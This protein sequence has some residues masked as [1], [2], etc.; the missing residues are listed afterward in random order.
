MSFQAGP[1]LSRTFYG[2]TVTEWAVSLAIAVGSMVLMWAAGRLVLQRLQAVAARTSTDVDDLVAELLAKTKFLFVLL[3]GVWA[4]S[5]TLSLSPTVSSWITEILIVGLLLQGAFWSTGVVNY[6]IEKYRSAEVGLDPD[7]A[8]AMG[9]VSFVV[10]VAIWSVFLLLALQNLGIN[11]TTLVASLG[12]G[13]VAVALALQNVLG[14]LFASLSIVL[15]KPFVVGDFI[16]VDD[17]MGTVEHVGL[18]T[19]RVRSLGGEQLVFSNSDLLAS[20]IRNYKRMDERRIVFSFGVTYDTGHDRLK[21]IPGIVRSIVEALEQTR[22][23]RS[24]F[25][26]FGDSA[27]NFE[28]VYYMLVPDY[29]AYMDTQQAI[30]LELYRRLQEAGVDFAFP[31]RTVHV[32]HSEDRQGATQ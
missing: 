21:E 25:K 23:D 28:T 10:R 4:G 11:V 15:D 3:V 31:T 9:A 5:R 29:N 14:D 13:G 27:L 30:N 20:R 8:T 19:T 16:I 1:F 22:F 17:L 6:V 32:E 26:G 7:A 18:K 2:N 24:H 12:I